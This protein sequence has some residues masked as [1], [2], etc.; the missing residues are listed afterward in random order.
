MLDYLRTYAYDKYE[1]HV[2]FTKS[3][4]PR[5]MASYVFRQIMLVKLYDN[6]CMYACMH[7]CMYACMYMYVCIYGHC[8]YKPRVHNIY[9]H[10][11]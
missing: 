9:Y 4:K 8:N 5:G 11:V 6:P 7:V 2:N 10:Y 1:V 3:T